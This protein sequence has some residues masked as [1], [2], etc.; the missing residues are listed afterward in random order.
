[1]PRNPSAPPRARLGL[2]ALEDRAL[3]ALSVSLVMGTIVIDGGPA[4]DTAYVQ[5]VTRMG[6]P[7]YVVYTHD[8]AAGAVI[9]EAAPI[10]KSDVTANLVVFDGK[11]GDDIFWNDAPGLKSSAFGGKGKDT[12][13]GSPSGPDLNDVLY[14]GDDNDF[15]DG[16]GGFDILTGGL[17]RDTIY[18]G[19]DGDQIW[20]YG[21]TWVLSHLDGDDVLH[22]GDGNDTIDGGAGHDQLFGEGENDALDGHTGNDAL[23]GGGGRDS[24]EGSWDNDWLSGGEENDTLIG[25]FGKDT[26][27]GDGGDDWLAGFVYEAGAGDGEADELWGGPGADR[28]RAEWYC[29]W[30]CDLGFH[31]PKN[32]EHFK[33]F[34]NGLDQYW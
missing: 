10:S 17:G 29:D 32:R 25:G 21:E 13:Y 8:G 5:A 9:D 28:F 27:F 14:G 24:L 15:I 22:G 16:R 34:V 26:L 3:P 20:G 30:R 12:L 4:H 18:G 19:P 2:E 7:S 11:D 33:D 1:M 6:V 23:F 31:L